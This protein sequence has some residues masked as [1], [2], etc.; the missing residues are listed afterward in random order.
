MAK[1]NSRTE[2][3]GTRMKE[4]EKESET[5]IDPK[6]H[7][8][9]RI[10]GHKFSKYTKGMKKPFDVIFSKA[11]ELTAIDAHNEFNATTSYVQSDEITLVLPSL[12][13][14]DKHKGQNAPK[15]GHTSG[16]RTQKLAS[17]V[18]GFCTMSFNKHFKNILENEIGWNE[19]KTDEMGKYFN[20]MKE[21][22]GNAWF[23]CRVFGVPSDEEAFNAVMWR[24]RDAEKNSRSMFAQTF[25]S[26]KE[27]QNK[28]GLEQV[29]FCK[30][31]TGKDWELIEDRFKYGILVKKEK[32]LKPVSGGSMDYAQN[33]FVERSRIK[34]YSEKLIFSDE[35]VNKIMRKYL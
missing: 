7:M 6:D 13:N 17:L 31:K 11:M 18:A 28:T 26:H 1:K 4:Y 3:L 22:I 10:D 29:Q 32:Y 21:K 20:K 2:S 27:L 14:T 33:E 19:Y 12:M 25:C 16:G 23:D 34:T 5:V 8:I 9:I 30:E 24:V 15:W 35:A